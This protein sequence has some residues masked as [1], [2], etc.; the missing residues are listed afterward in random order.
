MRKV[1]VV[2]SALLV[3]AL[4][5]PASAAGAAST[6][7]AKRVLI[8]MDEREQME[9]LAKYLKDKGGIDSTIV[10]QQSAPEDWS[11]FDAVVGYVHGALQEP[12]ELKIIDY[13]KNGGR[14]V[15]LHH[16]ISS[17]KSKNKYYFDFLGVRMT[18]IEKAREAAKPG[19]HYAWREPVDIT[20][21][22]LNPKHYITS[23]DVTWPE[24]TPFKLEGNE[25]PREF[26][27]FTLRGEAYMNVFFSD[28]DKTV[29][30]GLKYL[31]D[32][33]NAQYMQQAEGWLKPAGKGWIVYLQP[34]HFKEEFE[35]PAVSQMILNAI[36]WKPEAS[37]S[38]SGAKS[39]SSSKQAS[40]A[41]SKA[42]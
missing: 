11:A 42:N 32:R 16:M 38:S 40:K 9:T 4:P 14:F 22:N 7:E 12:I 6:A 21:V 10:D 13:T 23:H 17:G 35:R 15:C 41:R 18:G 3:F 5:A 37:K 33:N 8:V 39:K 1:L 27:A 26:P 30:L 34:G 36:T 29:L 24:K 19:D 20:V 31:D 28:T 2:L 25:P